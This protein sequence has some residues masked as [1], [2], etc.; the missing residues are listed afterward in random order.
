MIR[1]MSLTAKVGIVT[2]F[3]VLAF[4][5]G[6]SV[7][8]TI[9]VETVKEVIVEKEVYRFIDENQPVQKWID[10][11]NQA[12]VYIYPEGYTGQIVP[13]YSLVPPVWYK[14]LLQT[15]LNDNDGVMPPEILE[16]VP[17]EWYDAIAPHNTPEDQGL[18]V[19]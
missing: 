1:G 9:C 8:G 13:L 18:K 2:V 3:G 12:V 4:I 16:S 19:H 17:K 10:P 14:Q 7:G 15:I 6:L 11:D 5:V